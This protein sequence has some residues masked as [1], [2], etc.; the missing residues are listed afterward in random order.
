[1][2]APVVHFEIN[3]RDGKKA[4]AFYA[5]LFGWNIDANNPMA[6]G[7]VDTGLKKGINGGIGQVEAG[8]LPFITFYAAVA[9]PQACLD[10]AVSLGGKVVLPVTEIP[11]MV[12]FALFADPEG[13]IVGIVKDTM[14]PPKPKP[15]RS[16]ARKTRRATARRRSR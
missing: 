7:L 2:G 5:D 1:M 10:K 11:N 14:P 15:R 6:Y 8:K 4:Q 12:T 16:A 13:N 9:E 3:A